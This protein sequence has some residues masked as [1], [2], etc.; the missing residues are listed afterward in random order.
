[1]WWWCTAVIGILRPRKFDLYQPRASLIGKIVLCQFY[2]FVVNTLKVLM[3]CVTEFSLFSPP[4]HNQVG[5]CWEIHTHNPIFY[6]FHVSLVPGFVCISKYFHLVNKM[7]NNC[8]TRVY[9]NVLLNCKV[10]RL[11]VTLL[12]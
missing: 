10:A 12:Q 2:A 3:D 9:R 4:L 11:H 7:S 1:M 8:P 6:L 5:R